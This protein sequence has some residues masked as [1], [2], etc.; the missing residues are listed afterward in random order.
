M[1]L[2]ADEVNSFDLKILPG[3]KPIT[4]LS[5]KWKQLSNGGY[6]PVDRGYNSDVYESDI[7]VYGKE[8]VI[9]GLIRIL[10]DN[11]YT[12]SEKSNKFELSGFNSAEKIFGAEINYSRGIT[13][14]IMNYG[15]KMQKS[16]KGF[17][18][19][20]T[21]RAFHIDPLN[22][23]N[24]PA[25]FPEINNFRGNPNARASLGIGFTGDSS[26]GIDKTDTYTGIKSFMDN[27]A[28]S[29]FFESVLTLKTEDMAGLRR[30]LIRDNRGE[31]ISAN[32]KT[33]QI[34]NNIPGVKNLF[35]PRRAGMGP[36]N[37]RIIEFTDMGMDKLDWWQIKMKIVEEI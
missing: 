3:F 12:G 31:A 4:K 24:A 36:F 25:K 17:F 29:G 19:K 33:G 23:E 37:I 30:F 14:A 10:E 5:I 32:S 11:R 15:S 26:A 2:S 1:I 7:T 13:A 28:D 8:D 20:L 9:D 18:L 6:F 22:P 34:I 21:L 16:W 35:G 27:R